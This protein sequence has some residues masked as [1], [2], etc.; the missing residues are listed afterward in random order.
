MGGYEGLEAVRP[1]GNLRLAV[2][3][4]GGRVATVDLEPW[5]DGVAMLQPLRDPALFAQA[6]VHAWGWHVERVPGEIDMAGDQLWRMAGDCQ[7]GAAAGIA[8]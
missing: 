5:I 2:A 7:E 3:F 6:R 4:K 8:P 1:A